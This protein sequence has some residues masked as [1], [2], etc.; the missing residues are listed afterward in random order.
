MKR[1][2]GWNSMQCA[3]CEETE[4]IPVTI[5]FK[6]GSGWVMDK[7]TYEGH[8]CDGCIEYLQQVIVDFGFVTK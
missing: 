7:T 5:E 6:S 4:G 8:L 3:R 1:A 2:K